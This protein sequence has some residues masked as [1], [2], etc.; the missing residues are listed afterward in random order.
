MANGTLTR[1]SAYQ[2][3]GMSSDAVGALSRTE[4]GIRRTSSRY[5]QAMS[6]I[7]PRSLATI[8]QRF[9]QEAAVAGQT[10]YYGWGSGEDRVEGPSIHLAMALAR[11]WGNCGLEMQETL[12]FTDAWLMTATYIDSETGF[13]FERQFRQSKRSKIH[14][15]HDEERKMDMRFQIGQSKCTRNLICNAVPRWLVNKG[16][17]AAKD[18]VRRTIEESIKKNGIASVIASAVK[19]LSALGVTEDLIL[20]KYDRPT[21][22]ALTIEDLVLI[23]G[24]ICAL[25]ERQDTV[26]NLYPAPKEEPEDKKLTPGTL[27]ELTQQAEQAEQDQPKGTVVASPDVAVMTAERI[28]KIETAPETLDEVADEIEQTKPRG[29]RGDDEGPP[30]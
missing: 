26:Q 5:T 14:G 9:L 4:A 24:D 1:E 11:C 7:K 28:K 22:N 15:K 20:F 2:D 21:I 30:E 12:D 25:E 3:S 16:I 17:T 6:V 18:G 10:F 8:E 19:K 29:P 23:K 13:T 27:D